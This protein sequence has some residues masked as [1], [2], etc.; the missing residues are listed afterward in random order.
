[1]STFS[2]SV[3]VCLLSLF[4]SACYS[5]SRDTVIDLKGTI[6]DAAGN[7]I[8]VSLHD[9]VEVCAWFTRKNGDFLNSKGT[10]GGAYVLCQPLSSGKNGVSFNRAEFENYESF[11]ILSD[12]DKAED[13]V[14]IVEAHLK[15]Q[16]FTGPESY[17]YTSLGSITSVVHNLGKNGGTVEFKAI[18]GSTQKGV[19][20]ITVH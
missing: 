17:R 2:R 8:E 13:S 12:R 11:F 20:H 3:V 1:M 5:V 15:L 10:L 19:N 16:L 7:P 9:R 6:T 4:C 18:I 14:D